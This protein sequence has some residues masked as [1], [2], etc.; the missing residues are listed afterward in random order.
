LVQ[1]NKG[2]DVN[3]ANEATAC[4]WQAA[5]SSL[6]TSRSERRTG[7]QVAD[8]PVHDLNATLPGLD[9]LRLNYRFQGRDDPTKK[10]T[11]ITWRFLVLGTLT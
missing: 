8:D 4:G 1:A 10:L 6:G 3:A 9:H 2:T 7:V 5:E 11:C